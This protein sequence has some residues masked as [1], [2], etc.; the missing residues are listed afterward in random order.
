MD[1]IGVRYR[2]TLF[3][4]CR[5]LARR[6][7]ARRFLACR[8]PARRFLARRFLARHFPACR[9]P[10]MPLEVFRWN[11]LYSRHLAKRSVAKG[12]I[13][14]HYIRLALARRGVTIAD[15]RYVLS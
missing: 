3:L 14:A 7:R 1:G 9:F 12:R 2:R 4:S 13:E 5:F 11:G 6:F 10:A 8:F 15:I